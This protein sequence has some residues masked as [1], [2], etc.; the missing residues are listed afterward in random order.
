MFQTF[1]DIMII[2][3]PI[4]LAVIGLL[5]ARVN[6]KVNSVKHDMDDNTKLTKEVSDKVEIVKTQTD[7]IKDELVQ[8]TKELGEAIGKAV[9]RAE[10]KVESEVDKAKAIPDAPIKVEVVNEP[11]HVLPQETPPKKDT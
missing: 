6:A 7:G 5:T 8:K 1:K 3:T 10:Q 11:L 9:G 4:I 2:L